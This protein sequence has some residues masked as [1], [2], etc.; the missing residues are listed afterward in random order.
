MLHA[1]TLC[2]TSLGLLALAASAVEGAYT[3]NDFQFGAFASQGYFQ[4]TDNDYLGDSED[5]SFDFR[6]YGVNV[7]WS[8]GKFRAGA[9]VFGQSL[10]YYGDDE[11][12]LDW[13]T[14]DYQ[15]SQQFG[16]RA[17]RVKMPRGLYNETLDLDMLRPFVFLPASVYDPRLRD[18]S[19][20]FN[21]AMAYGNV[22][23]GKAGSL[24]YK[25]F[26][27]DIPMSIDSGAANYFNNDVDYPVTSMAMDAIYGGSLF[28]NTPV[29]GLRFGYSYSAF[30]GMES[31]RFIDVPPLSFYIYK[32]SGT[33]ERQ[34]LSAEY[35]TGDW[36]FAF[37]VGHDYT[38]AGVTTTSPFYPPFAGTNESTYGYVSAA[39]RINDWLELGAYYSYSKDTAEVTGF[40]LTLPDL[41][42]HDFA[43]SAKFD[44]TSY[45]IFKLEAHYMDGVGKIFSS[46]EHPQPFDQREDNWMFFAA[47]VSFYY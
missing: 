4:S 14:A 11:I 12:M 16:L 37:E 24:D 22:E 34:L 46:Y 30:K 19:S 38:R 2:F 1:N 36:V 23:L 27:G 31:T 29:V 13:A 33:Y 43:I 7:S 32:E 28:W 39:R 8:K 9:Q 25:I 18:F 45:M 42:Q 26:G 6:E 21:G 47:K 17:G 10:G 35:A 40:D 15:F 44:V 3:W 20:A 41:E 5:G